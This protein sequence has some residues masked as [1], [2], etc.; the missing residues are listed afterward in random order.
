ML[1]VA[2]SWVELLAQRAVDS[3]ACGPSGLEKYLAG[4]GLSL[5]M[6]RDQTW[7]I[8]RDFNLGIVEVEWQKEL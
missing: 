8:V 7:L 2:S 3:R 5:K 1:Q 4:V 6:Q